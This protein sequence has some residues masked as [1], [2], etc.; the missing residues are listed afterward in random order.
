[1]PRPEWLDWGYDDAMKMVA[2]RALYSRSVGGLVKRGDLSS[3]FGLLGGG[4]TDNQKAEATRASQAARAQLGTLGADEAKIN[5]ATKALRAGIVTPE[6]AAAH[7][8][9]AVPPKLLQLGRSPK[10]FGAAMQQGRTGEAL[11]Q[12]DFLG[13]K[14]LIPGS[15]HF[16]L[17]TAAASAAGNIGARLVPKGIDYFGLQDYTTVPGMLRNLTT[18]RLSRHVPGR[19]HDP[20]VALRGRGVQSYLRGGKA[21]Q[22]P[23]LKENLNKAQMNLVKGVTGKANVN[24]GGPL[25]QT[26]EDAMIRARGAP[27]SGWFHTLTGGAPGIAGALI[28]AVAREWL[29]PGGYRSGRRPIKDLLE[30]N[31]VLN[32]PRPG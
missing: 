6:Q 25:T 28:P 16:S 8:R 22:N 17:P 24:L 18:G 10:A 13:L 2:E 12:L 29:L 5:E 9:T 30:A 21:S 23:I 32:A 4:P 31:R 11:K 3:L 19:L 14:N 1:M 7:M 26:V 20:L 15:G 27:G